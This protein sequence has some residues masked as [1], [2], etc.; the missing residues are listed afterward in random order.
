MDHDP[1]LDF[2]NADRLIAAADGALGKTI[3]GLASGY[4][5][6]LRDAD[7]EVYRWGELDEDLTDASERRWIAA[8]F[9]M[10]VRDRIA[11]AVGLSPRARIET[12]DSLLRWAQHAKR[13][14]NTRRGAWH[15]RAYDV[16]YAGI[17]GAAGQGIPW[18]WSDLPRLWLRA[19][20][21]ALIAALMLAV[22]TLARR[23]PER[24]L[25]LNQRASDILTLM[26]E[27]RRFEKDTFLNVGTARAEVYLRQ[28]ELTRSRLE[29]VVAEAKALQS[30]EVEQAMLSDI[31]RDMRVYASGYE[32][33]A[34]LIRQGTIR[35]GE[36]AN[37]RLLAY[38]ASAHEAEK[39]C[40]RLKELTAQRLTTLQRGM[41]ALPGTEG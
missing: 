28:W 32:R 4:L 41:F 20:V 27:E 22:P 25:A 34:G 23:E 18:R 15:S 26:L 7:A 36:D 1:D 40:A 12:P 11:N 39:S 13:R 5:M 31:E 17:F 37:E 21:T 6:A 9:M 16:V 24:A 10:G 33:V 29:M 35:T 19:S 3:Q 2:S 14:L 30:T 8:G 38:K